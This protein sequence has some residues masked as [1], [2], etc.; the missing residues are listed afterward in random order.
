M[1]EILSVAAGLLVTIPLAGYLIMFIFSKQL[2][3]N[4]R[5]SVYLAID[6][7]TL[8][9]IFSV[10]FL[11]IMIWGKSF[12]WLIMLILI[13]LAVIFVLIHWKLRQEINFGRVF[14]GYWRFNFLL[15]FFVY[16]VLIIVGLYQRISWLV[17]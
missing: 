6:F 17:A 14:K 11:I 2:T 12:L 4:H 15:F 16:L 13:F 8:L 10:H 9:F 1:T 5:K 7:S 3:G